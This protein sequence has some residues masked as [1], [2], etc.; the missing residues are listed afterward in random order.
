MLSKCWF[1]PSHPPP[2]TPSLKKVK[3]PTYRLAIPSHQWEVA[4]CFPR[5]VQSPSHLVMTR[6]TQQNLWSRPSRNYRVPVHCYSLSN[7][8]EQFM[9]DIEIFVFSSKG[10]THA[11]LFGIIQS[12]KLYNRISR[13]I[14]NR[15]RKYVRVL[16]W[17]L[18]VMDWRKN[19]ESKIS[20]QCLFK[21]CIKM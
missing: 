13:R 8:L 9:K 4:A 15:I 17:G 20:W 12:F 3:P 10:S 21:D 11:K 5:N 19:R 18:E 6:M 14:R 2:P 1:T 16:I 7:I